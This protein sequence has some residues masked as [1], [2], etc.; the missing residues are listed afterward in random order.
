MG[1]FSTGLSSELIDA[2][3]K[4]H[5]QVFEDEPITMIVGECHEGL[6]RLMGAY[7][8]SCAAFMTAWNPFSQKTSPEQN[9][10]QQEQLKSLIQ[11]IELPFIEG[12]G[13]H[14]DGQWEGE[15]SLLVPG[16]EQTVADQIARQFEQNAYLWIDNTGCPMLRLLR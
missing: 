16:I 3:R 10:A 7:D 6:L 11:S 5:Y 4:T 14:P 9:L 13:R 1:E 12:E 15:P 8:C 2:Y